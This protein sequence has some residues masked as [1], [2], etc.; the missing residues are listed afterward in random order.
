MPSYLVANL[1]IHDSLA[2]VENIG[3][4]KARLI[5]Q[6]IITNNSDIKTIDYNNLPYL[7]MDGQKV[8]T[9]YEPVD[10]ED[11]DK[12]APK[13]SVVY[14]VSYDYD[15]STEHEWSFGYSDDTVISGLDDYVCIKEAIRNYEGK[16]QVSMDDI[17]KIEQEQKEKFKNFEK[18]QK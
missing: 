5:M 2:D 16:P 1:E 12:V 9:T 13:K 17:K 4:G 3:D 10:S 6:G 18:E 7:K 14:S 11:S 8:T 15:P